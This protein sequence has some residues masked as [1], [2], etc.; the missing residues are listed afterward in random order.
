MGSFVDR[1]QDAANGQVSEVVA[2]DEDFKKKFP[3]L[4]DFVVT[5]VVGKKPRKTSTVTLFA[6]SGWWKLCV[7][8]RQRTCTLWRTGETVLE[9]VKAAEKAIQDGSAD[10]R[11]NSQGSYQ[12]KRS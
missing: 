4:Y 10:W 11:P 7:N 9:A 1:Y 2:V 5:G 8:D 12:G 3:A 6:E